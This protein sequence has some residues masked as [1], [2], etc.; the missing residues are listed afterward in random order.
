MTD[1][2][3]SSRTSWR[4]AALVLRLAFNGLARSRST[5]ALAVTILA[6]GLAAPAVFFSL[7]VGSIRPLP[8][9]EGDRVIR[10]DVLQPSRG[11]RPLAVMP[12]EVRDLRSVQ[13]LEAVG[14]FRTS[15]ATVVDPDVAATRVSLAELSPEV[16]PLLRVAPLIGRLAASDDSDRTVLIGHDVWLDMYDGDSDVLGRP[17][18]VDGVNRTVIGVMP[19][20]FGFPFKQNAWVVFDPDRAAGAETAP[21]ELVGRLA[22]GASLDGAT[23]EVGVRWSR[24]D[25]DRSVERTGG[26]VAV[27][28]YTGGRGEGGE[29]VAFIGLVLIALCLLLIACA[30]VANLLLVRATERVHSLG[31]QSALGASR[32]QI[33]AQLL[34][35]ALLLALAG[36]VLGVFLAQGA[37]G[38]IQ[39]RLAEE[40]FGYF[41]MRMAVDGPVLLF[42]SL[43]ML[44]TSIAAGTL[45][46]IRVMSIDVRGVL[47]RNGGR[48]GI[49]GGGRWGRVFVT[50][51]LAL[52]CAAL[53]AA[54]LTA[55]SMASARDFGGDLPT[56]EILIAQM[57][58][59]GDWQ[60]DPTRIQVL[61]DDLEQLPNVR[62][63]AVAS[64]APGFME[65]WGSIELDGVSYERP[66]DRERLL[67]NAVTP[68]FFGVIDAELRAGRLL[69]EQDADQSARVAVVNESFVTRFSSDR[70]VLGRSIRIGAEDDSAPWHTVVGVVS[71]TRIGSGERVRHDR[72]YLPLAQAT[73]V[74]AM[75][76]LRGA[77]D[78]ASLAPGLRT[79]VA[80][81]D[82][83]TAL[84]GIRTLADGHAYM[85]RVPRA[86]GALAFGGG[87]A[88][89]LV[90]AAGLY[91]LLTFRVRQRRREL[92]VRL[93][94]G[95]DG[96][97]L[98]RE[99]MVFALHQLVPAVAIGLT[100]AWLA[101][102]LLSVVVLGM[103][104]RSPATLGAVGITF[105]AV[106][107]AAA[108]IPTA[109][110]AATDPAEALRAE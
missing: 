75:I 3:R 43:L 85:T 80:D 94:L 102:P 14:A 17:V 9:P 110:A 11:G 71:D 79:A 5:T 97:R 31:I 86:M 2:R 12:A 87:V 90:A 19:E 44:T 27:E 96:R 84:S 35:E 83:N 36:G 103:N 74:S 91:G 82:P 51:Q 64:G 89:L 28:P 25:G 93:A 107:L 41:W 23:A 105:L 1:T 70:D 45:P 72:A 104:P 24:A 49:P 95:A 15:P 47:Q 16:L 48:G 39:T 20:G 61:A 53:V 32:L 108:A 13:S 77:S 42:T 101:A 58:L 37:V 81:V 78:A 4:Q 30:N 6:L 22:Q 8:V 98:A 52:S 73:P 109:R 40:H 50:T 26:V 56:D 66:A 60:A 38:A 10:I 29:A 106:G 63:V 33:G 88:G 67:W 7:L 69:N 54:G 57:G 46:A 55:R 34:T 21:V 59:E 76:L 92:G 99:T 62:G 18:T 100:L 68:G 65:S